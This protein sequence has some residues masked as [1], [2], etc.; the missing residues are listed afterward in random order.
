MSHVIVALVRPIPRTH[1]LRMRRELGSQ[2]GAYQI[3]E[4][5]ELLPHEHKQSTVLRPLGQEQQ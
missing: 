2:I 3:R 1:Y 4:T 5:T